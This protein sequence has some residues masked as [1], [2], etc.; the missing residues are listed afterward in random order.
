MGN[1][2]FF[3]LGILLLCAV[4]YGTFLAFSYGFEYLVNVVMWIWYNPLLFIMY[5]GAY[6]L[7]GIV[8]SI[9]KL[10]LKGREDRDEMAK[11]TDNAKFKPDYFQSIYKQKLKWWII[12]W[13]ISIIDEMVGNM[14]VNVVQWI[15]DKLSNVYKKV[16]KA[17]LGQ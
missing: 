10:W 8:W 7:I 11:Y 4:G 15:T 9:C 5:V 1:F 16:Y 12:F 3:L 17:A 2:G 6:L 13:P 14:I